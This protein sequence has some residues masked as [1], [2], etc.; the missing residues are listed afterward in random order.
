[1]RVLFELCVIG[2]N[3]RNAR[4]M[5]GARSEPSRNERRVRVHDRRATQQSRDAAR[6][7]R[8]RQALRCRCR[9]RQRRNANEIRSDVAIR[10]HLRCD[11]NRFVTAL[12]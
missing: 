2:K 10:R 7:E 9:Q 12:T 8:Q 5:C 3:E 4:A 6:Q 1:M 11:E